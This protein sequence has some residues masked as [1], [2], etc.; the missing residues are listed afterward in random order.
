M[1]PPSPVNPTTG[2]FGRASFI[3][4]APGI[5]TPSEPPRVAK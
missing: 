3:P 2:T 4:M 5:P 1:L